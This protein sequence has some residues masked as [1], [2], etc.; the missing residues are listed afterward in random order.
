MF[1]QQFRGRMVEGSGDVEVAD[2][3]A[4]R[5]GE[6][7][8]TRRRTGPFA[9]SDLAPAL[10]GLGVDAL[11]LAGVSTGGV[12]ASTVCAA[13]DEDLALTVLS[14]A[15]GRPRPRPPRRP[16]RGACPAARPRR[17][18]GGAPGREEAA[19][20]RGAAEVLQAGDR[21]RLVT[22]VSGRCEAG[23]VGGRG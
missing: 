13:A 19:G 14:D 7:V 3:L 8:V 20:E 22:C 15:V 12:V 5:A 10:R 23:V 16:G 4:P 9:G 18:G 2:A 6:P 1:G 17:D 11:V 21:H